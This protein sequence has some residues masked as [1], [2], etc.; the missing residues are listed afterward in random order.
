[1]DRHGGDFFAAMPVF[2]CHTAGCDR[3]ALQADRERAPTTASRRAVTER[4]SGLTANRPQGYLY[5]ITDLAKYCGENDFCRLAVSGI[6][7]CFNR[8]GPW[9]SPA[10]RQYPFET[11]LAV[12]RFRA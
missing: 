3:I 9:R 8:S 1:M 5:Q 2:C 11:A 10:G 4:A 6:W 7:V 12:Q